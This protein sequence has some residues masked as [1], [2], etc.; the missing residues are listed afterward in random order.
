M[1]IFEHANQLGHDEIG[2]II[3][4]KQEDVGIILT[5]PLMRSA[6]EASPVKVMNFAAFYI[7]PKFTWMASLLLRRIMTETNIEYVD[8]TASRSMRKVNEHLGFSTSAT[9][10]LVVPLAASAWRPFKSAK[11]R[12]YKPG[13][14]DLFSN[15]MARVLDDHLK[16]GCRVLT[17]E[18]NGAM[19][20]LILADKKRGHLPSARVILAENRDLV[21]NSIGSLARYLLARGVFFLEMDVFGK[22]DLW[23]SSYRTRSAPVQSTKPNTTSVI[24]HTYTELVFLNP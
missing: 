18:H 24:D 12:S 16:L 9:G 13:K 6:Y 22:P 7:K 23:E 20:P 15:H 17:V 10:L 2:Y 5:I 4:N 11:I 3:A 19:Y 21:I 14:T 8:I 1:K